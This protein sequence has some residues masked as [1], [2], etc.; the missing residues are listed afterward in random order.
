MLCQSHH[1]IEFMGVCKRHRVTPSLFKCFPDHI[2]ALKDLSGFTPQDL[3][4]I[5]WAYATVGT[6]H[7]RLL[8]CIA[9]HI[10]VLKVLS[11]FNSQSLSN[12]A[13]AS[14]TAG[15]SHPNCKVQGVQLS[16]RRQFSLDVC[17]H[18]TG[19]PTFVLLTRTHVKSKMGE[20][21]SQCLAN[22]GWSY[23]VAH[24]ADPSLD[25]ILISFV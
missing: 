13:W 20:Y 16:T 14:A 4:N 22:I 2:I 3:A 25:S 19:G 10:V 21:N 1:C 23:A 11:G 5:S 15:K 12:I 8:R 24:V 18:L 17:H 7:P 6:S 9:N